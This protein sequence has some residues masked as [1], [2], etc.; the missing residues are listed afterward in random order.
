MKIEGVNF[1]EAVK[2]LARKTGIEI[3]IIIVLF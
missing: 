2:L 3:V 1:P